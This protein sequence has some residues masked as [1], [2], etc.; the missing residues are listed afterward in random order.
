MIAMQDIQTLDI[1][2]YLFGDINITAFRMI[3]RDSPSVVQVLQAWQTL[4]DYGFQDRSYDSYSESL[5][6]SRGRQRQP[7]AMPGGRARNEPIP[8]LPHG[9]L[10]VG[11]KGYG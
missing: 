5:M 9:M 8:P 4:V 3:D 7:I 11:Q 6:P 1:D 10:K 2:S